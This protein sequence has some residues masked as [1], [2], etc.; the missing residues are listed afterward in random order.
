MCRCT[1]YS[2]SKEAAVEDCKEFLEG[3]CFW[4]LI[5]LATFWLR[6]CSQGNTWDCDCQGIQEQWE[7]P[8]GLAGKGLVACPFLPP[9]LGSEQPYNL[10]LC[11]GQFPGDGERP[12]QGWDMVQQM[13]LAQRQ[14]RLW[15]ARDWPCWI[16]GGG[17][18]GPGADVGSGILRRAGQ[19]RELVKGRQGWWCSWGPSSKL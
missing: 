3:F 13:G 2:W 15:G 19:P 11:F 9:C 7:L 1:E 12:R 5:R 8:V 10:Y 14:A 6:W 4:S 17:T 18:D 16:T